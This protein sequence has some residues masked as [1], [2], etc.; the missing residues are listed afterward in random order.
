MKYL[1][2]FMSE[3]RGG[4]QH[5]NRFLCQVFVPETMLREILTN[6]ILLEIVDVLFPNIGRRLD[7]NFSVPQ[8]QNWLGRGLVCESA[9]LPDRGFNTIPVHQYGFTE[10]V[11]NKSTH[12]TFDCVFRM[13]LVGG[14]NIVPRFFSYWQHYIQNAGKGTESSFDF[15]FPNSYY[16]SIYLSLYDRQNNPTIT[17]HFERVYPMTVSTNG[18]GW[19][20]ENQFMTLPVS[21]NYSTWKIIPYTPPPILT[22]EI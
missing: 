17:Y 20:A 3:F 21:F 2:Q 6:N 11:P 14:D 15:R 22:I 7:T 5:N 10:E 12:S 16:G 13:P 1:S 18:V 8:V 4:F 19:E 9:R